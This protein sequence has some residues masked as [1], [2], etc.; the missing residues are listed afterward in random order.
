LPRN[1]NHPNSLHCILIFLSPPS[2]YTISIPFIF[3]N[4]LLFLK[5]SIFTY[6]HR[7]FNLF[8]RY[9]HTLKLFVSS[10]GVVF[11]TFW[12]ILLLL[13]VFSKARIFL[14]HRCFWAIGSVSD[15]RKIMPPSL[16]DPPL[17][18]TSSVS[19]LISG[20]I[21][22]EPVPENRLFHDLRGLQWRINLGVL[23]SSSS[24]TY[25]DD[26]RRATANSR[27]R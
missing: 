3:I 18:K 26:L 25:V 6:P 1:L 14:D 4:S 19:S 27:R 22:E 15:C 2:S 9:I 5:S 20:T 17:S 10:Y 24:S 11:Q 21:S 23:P 7:N 16:L 13:F 12:P 8:P